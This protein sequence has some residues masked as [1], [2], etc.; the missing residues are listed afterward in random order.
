MKKLEFIKI[1]NEEYKKKQN[2]K[3]FQEELKEKKKTIT[4]FRKLFPKKN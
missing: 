2:S 3:E 4:E 1:I